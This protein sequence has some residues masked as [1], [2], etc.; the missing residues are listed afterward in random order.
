[1]IT[2]YYYLALVLL[3]LGIWGFFIKKDTVSILSLIQ[4]L[5]TSLILLFVVL[6]Q[7]QSSV[8]GLVLAFFTI[9]VLLIVLLLGILL[10]FYCMKRG[11]KYFTELDEEK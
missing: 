8:D 6:A 7:K 5:F 1:M 3:F 10:V 9:F 11:K 4:L 2:V